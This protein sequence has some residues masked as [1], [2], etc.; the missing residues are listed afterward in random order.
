MLV[1]ALADREHTLSA[2]SVAVDDN[3]R[4]FRFGGAMFINPDN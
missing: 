4:F 3:F 2:Y 1:S